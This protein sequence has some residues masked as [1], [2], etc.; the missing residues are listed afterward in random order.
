M[1][2]YIN[3]C[4]NILPMLLCDCDFS[5]WTGSA[6]FS[7]DASLG[8]DVCSSFISITYVLWH[9]GHLTAFPKIE[10]EKINHKFFYRVRVDH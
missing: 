7:G 3:K 10:I 2:K 1:L 9:S 4:D 6:C 5:K 8:G